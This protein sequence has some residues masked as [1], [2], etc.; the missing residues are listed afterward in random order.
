MITNY[1]RYIVGLFIVALVLSFTSTVV[2]GRVVVNSS[3]DAFEEDPP[4]PSGGTSEGLSG[5]RSQSPTLA[6]YIIQAAGYY[7]KG[8]SQTLMMM[9]KFEMSDLEGVDIP[10]LETQ[11]NEAI[12][13]LQQARDTYAALLTKARNTRYNQDMIK[14]LTSFNYTSFKNEKGLNSP[15]F[16]DV[17]YFL[18]RG[19]VIGIY[20][21]VLAKV[22]M[23]L[24][25]LNAAKNVLYANTFP[26]NTAMWRLNQRFSETQLFGQYVAEVFYRLTTGE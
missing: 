15:I 10:A 12:G 1:K 2:Y 17:K 5:A 6:T 14:K 8:Y 9:N 3:E 23:I 22:D 25:D 13:T 19:D 26:T 16:N 7:L 21:E 11:V 4:P 24:A 20:A 18:S